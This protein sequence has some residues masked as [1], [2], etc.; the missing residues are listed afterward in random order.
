MTTPNE[1]F[2]RILEFNEDGERK[3]TDTQIV[4]LMQK[5]YQNCGIKKP[6]H[7]KLRRRQHNTGTG[8]FKG[9]KPTFNSVE[10]D[11]EG[12][13]VGGVGFSEEECRRIASEV[14]ADELTVLDDTLGVLIDEHLSKRPVVEIHF[15]DS[16]VK[17]DEL[18]HE[19]FHEVLLKISAGIPV[20]LVGPTG[21]GKTHLCEQVARALGTTFTFNSMSEGVSER[22]VFGGLLPRKDG[23]LDFVQSPF[24]H[25]YT[26][27]GLHLFDEI[28]SSDPN[29]LVKMNAALSNK[30]LSLPLAGA[31]PLKMHQG[32]VPMAAANTYG[33][34]ASR[35]YTGRNPLDEATRNRYHMGT[36][37]IDYDTNLERRLADALDS[38]DWLLDWAWRV[39]EVINSQ[40]L[41][42]TMG[43]RNI[44]DAARL[45]KAG[46]TEEMVKKTYFLSWSEDER[47]RV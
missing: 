36:V 34:G 44:L 15:K 18:V 7:V 35:Q 28:D 47:N 14:V 33:L 10:Y 22:E 6:S 13:P 24:T 45:I 23:S 1:G 31:E 17:F 5:Q 37:E 41:R 20:M 12:L 25:T 38:P 3:L 19:K 26:N 46:A 4:E 8:P 29:L 27:G 16:T 2:V 11:A 39:R 32:F 9:S 21:A 42:H 43:T 40:G 30:M